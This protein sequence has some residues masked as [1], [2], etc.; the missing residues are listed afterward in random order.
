[1]QGLLT[2]L[3]GDDHVDGTQGSLAQSIGST[4]LPQVTI[5]RGE[6]LVCKHRYTSNDSKHKVGLAQCVLE[7]GEEVTGAVQLE[8]FNGKK[9]SQGRGRLD[10][11]GFVSATADFGCEYRCFRILAELCVPSAQCPNTSQG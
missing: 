5:Q 6:E 11:L 7:G 4:E 10:G 3:L 1:M 2:S 8:V 9:A